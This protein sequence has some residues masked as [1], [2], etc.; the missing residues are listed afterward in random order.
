MLK[1][2]SFPDDVGNETGIQ[3][4]VHCNI[5]ISYSEMTSKSVL[6]CIGREDRKSARCFAHNN[7]IYTH[8]RTKSRMRDGK[9][10]NSHL[11]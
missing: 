9:E 10:N 8:T 6:S 5:G 2:P 7:C 4:H 3:L 11:T 1:L